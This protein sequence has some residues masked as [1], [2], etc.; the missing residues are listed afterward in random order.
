MTAATASG[1]EDTRTR[2]LAT[3]LQL[4]TEHGVEGTSLQMIADALG[5]TKAAVY[6]HF[7]TKDEI[8]GAVAEPGLR[9]LELVVEE[10]S[11]LRRR[12]AQIDHL[13]TG[14]VDVVVRHRA[15]VA[16]FARD[17]GV[18]RALADSWS[19]IY[20]GRMLELFAGPEADESR[21]IA[22]H[23]AIVGIALTGGAPQF[24]AL[25]DDTLRAHLVEV[26]RRL[27]GRPRRAT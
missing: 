4:F 7:K 15:L 9:E 6:Y 25:P 20:G 5:V 17:P 10:A 2:L 12:G 22:A 24:A 23:A 14:F 1:R 8:A 11:R 3:A 27:L 26:G 21:A 16:L 19:D 18:T 13:L